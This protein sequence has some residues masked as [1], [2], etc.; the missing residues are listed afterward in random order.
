MA[1]T[2]LP[3][4]P[5]LTADLS[6]IGGCLKQKPEDFIVEEIPAY[7]PSGEGEYLYL[8]IEKRDMGAEFFTR[9]LA[10][11]LQLRP[12]DVGTAGLKDRRAI[13]RQWVSVPAH[14]EP[15]LDQ[16][17]SDDLRL[18]E[19]RR[20]SN[21][22]KPGHL[23]GNRFEIL[24]RE[25]HSDAAQH[26][27]ALLARIQQMGLPNFYGEQRF[28]RDGETL[29][30]GLALLAGEPTGRVGSFL[31][32]LALSAVQSA[33]FNAYVAGRIRDQLFRTVLPGDV[34]MKWPFGGMFVAEDLPAEQPRLE[35]RE[36]IPGG[37]MFGKKM[38]RASGEALLREQQTLEAAGITPTAF[39]GFGKLL[40]G[41]RRYTFVY[42]DDLRGEVEAEGIRLW[43]SL[44]AGSYATILARELMHSKQL[45]ADERD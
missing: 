30:L 41:T 3:D 5:L 6:G 13:T 4:L 23:R 1:L 16:L 11:R 14:R 18:L 22:L 43:F 34:M 10:Q 27:P 37:P 20:H 35:Q 8:W 19:V 15:L 25:V 24:V 28:G 33:L 45:E 29:K 17:S 32:R 21:K 39:Q 40:A 26:L 38:F 36:I 44:P 31:R 9:Q 12:E 7:A 2:D 42:P